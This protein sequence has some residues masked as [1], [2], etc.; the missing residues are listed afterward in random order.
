M[1]LPKEA[2]IMYK[3]IHRWILLVSKH[4]HLT[5]WEDMIWWVPFYN[6]NIASNSFAR[7]YKF[8]DVIYLGWS[9]VFYSTRVGWIS[10]AYNHAR[11]INIKCWNSQIGKMD[12]LYSFCNEHIYYFLHSFH[13]IRYWITVGEFY[14]KTIE[15]HYTVYISS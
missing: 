14:F 2:Y 6:G 7:T 13:F 10:I 8:D 9:W 4:L 5:N 11:L 15:N 3:Y 1:N 12:Y